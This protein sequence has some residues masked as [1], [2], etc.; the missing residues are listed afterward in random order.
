MK[1]AGGIWTQAGG[2][3]PVGT[4][5][6]AATNSATAE[7]VGQCCYNLFDVLDYARI[8]PIAILNTAAIK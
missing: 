4:V 7:D 3:D 2:T 6:S 8:G 5:D 1:S